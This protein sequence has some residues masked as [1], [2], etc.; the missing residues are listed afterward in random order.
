MDTSHFAG[1]DDI[2]EDTVR[3]K[4]DMLAISYLDLFSANGI[5]ERQLGQ[6]AVI[7]LRKRLDNLAE[8]GFLD[9]HRVEDT[10][11]RIGFGVLLDAAAGERSVTNVHGEEQVV[12]RLLSIDRQDHVLRLMLDNCGDEAEEII[13]MVGTQVVFQGLGFLATERINA[14]TD[15][16]YLSD[17][18]RP[19]R[20]VGE[21]PC[22]SWSG[23]NTAPSRYRF[24][25]A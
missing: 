4:E 6:T 23:T 24:P 25:G 14:K 16:R 11:R 15:H 2:L 8:S 19:R 20:I 13:D 12:H 21:T 7:E 3:L 18:P 5:D 22:G 10:I 9:K 1:A 17:V